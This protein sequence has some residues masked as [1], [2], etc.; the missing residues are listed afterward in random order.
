MVF[1]RIRGTQSSHFSYEPKEK[2]R[3]S[4]R[5]FSH[6]RNQSTNKPDSTVRRTLTQIPQPMQSSSEMKAIFAAKET[7]M[8]S[9]PANHNPII[10]ASVRHRGAL[11]QPHTH[12]LQ[13]SP[14][15]LEPKCL[16]PYETTKKPET[17]PNDLKP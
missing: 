10:Q 16:K 12:E 8:Q 3:M 1:V 15:S 17:L 11:Q 6:R 9:F 13:K 14:Q 7:S 2:S 4:I 5:I